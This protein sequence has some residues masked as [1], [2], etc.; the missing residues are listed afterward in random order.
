M[1]TDLKKIAEKA[2]VFIAEGQWQAAAD[3]YDHLGQLYPGE[4]NVHHM[5]ALVLMAQQKWRPALQQ[6]DRAIS[7]DPQRADYLRSRGDL[8]LKM[9]ELEPAEKSYVRALELAPNDVHAM[10]NLGNALYRQDQPERAL[11]WYQRCAAVEPSHLQ[12][13]NNIGKTFQDCGDIESALAWYDKALTLAPDYAEARFNRALALLAKG[14]YVQGW[15]EY[16]WRFKRNTARQVYPHTYNIPRWDGTDYT[17]RHLL[18]HCEQGLGDVIQFSRYLPWVKALGGQLTVEAH[19]PLLPLLANRGEIDQLIAF[20]NNRPPQGNFD[21]FI[22]LLSLP[23]VFQTTLTSIPDNTPY[24]DPPQPSSQWVKEKVSTDRLRVGVVWSA[25]AT[26]PRRNFPFSRVRE[27]ICLPNIRFFSLQKEM[28]S[29]DRKALEQLKHLCHLGD[30]FNHFKDTA[31]AI[32]QLD[33]IISVDTAVAHLAGAMGKPVWILLPFSPDWRWLQHG[34]TSPWYPTARLFRQK[35][36]RDW[37][38]VAQAVRTELLHLS[39]PNTLPLSTPKEGPAAPAAFQSAS[40]YRQSGDH[41]LESGNFHAAIQA[42]HHALIHQP[43]CGH[44]LFYLGYAY[45]QTGQL[46]K[47]I[48]CYQTATTFDDRLEP[49]HRNMGLAYYQTGDLKKAAECYRRVLILNPYALDMHI[50]LGAIYAETHQFRKAQSCYQHVLD[51]EP[52][53]QS[54]RYNLANLFLKNSALQSAEKQYRLLVSQNPTNTKAL[55]NLGRTLHRMGQ[56]DEALNIFERVLQ[57]DLQQPL[58]HLNRGVG[59]LLKGQWPEGWREYEWRLKCPGRLRT[60]PHALTAPRWN[61]EPFKGKTLLIHGEQGF[62]DAIQFVRFLPQVKLLGGQVILETHAAL[63]PLFKTIESVDQFITLSSHEAPQV[64]YDLYFPMGSLAG[65]F[66]VTAHS[67]PPLTPYLFADQSK[68]AHWRSKLSSSGLN[69]GLTWAGSDTYP[70]RSIA[71][72]HFFELAAI[73]GVNWIGL[74]KGPAARQIEKADLPPNFKFINW[75]E[76]FEDFSDTAAAIASLDL[77]ISIDTAVAHLAGAMG[78]PVGLLLPQVPDWRWLLDREDTPW[79][80]TMRLFRQKQQGDWRPV[81]ENIARF[82][83]DGGWKMSF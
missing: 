25:S 13:L 12:A 20:D 23:L 66:D 63:I 17:G 10:I 60:Y 62:G 61:G 72:R 8:F 21:F 22:P 47:A 34:E 1:E 33:L 50:S 71:F 67:L 16:E 14:D 69:V 65:R 75:G 57:I 76:A 2:E 26:D 83:K 15:T 73:E 64:Q 37:S 82:I 51:L 56:I 74:Q 77:I 45:H 44:S 19:R 54:A 36:P 9:G 81:I 5:H 79:Y 30:H 38:A 41:H 3:I 39:K 28:G 31:E 29:N 48:A 68:T 43:D 46:E 53:N 6:L 35:R 4:P 80:A 42:Y 70:E 7:L 32:G 78:K 55:C 58:A 18:V 52:S 27:L 49:I 59:L 24:I 40:E 11:I